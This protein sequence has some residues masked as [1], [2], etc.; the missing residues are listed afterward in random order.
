[1]VI[2]E[3]GSEKR[4]GDDTPIQIMICTFKIV[5]LAIRYDKLICVDT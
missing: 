3:V 4:G 2:K 5:T 1:M